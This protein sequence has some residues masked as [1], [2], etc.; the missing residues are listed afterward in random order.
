MR[1]GAETA[2]EFFFL[3]SPT[4]RGRVRGD[5]CLETHL[6]FKSV[7]LFMAKLPVMPAFPLT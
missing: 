3:L 7:T 1:F 6:L 2:W 4:G 5:L